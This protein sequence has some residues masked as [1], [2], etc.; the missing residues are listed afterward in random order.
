MFP[1]FVYLDEWEEIPG[2]HDIAAYIQRVEKGSLT[3]ADRLFEKL[4]KVAD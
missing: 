2:H 1:I 3:L 4:L